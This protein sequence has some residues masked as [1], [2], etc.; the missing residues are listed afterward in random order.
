[1]VRISD[2][3]SVERW[4]VSAHF[5]FHQP[6]GEGWQL[7]YTTGLISEREC[8]RTWH[9]RQ[10]MSR[11]DGSNSCGGGKGS[12]WSKVKSN[13][14]WRNDVASSNW[15][16]RNFSSKPFERMSK[17]IELKL[18]SECR[19]YRVCIAEVSTCHAE[20]VRCGC[21]FRRSSTHKLELSRRVAI[22]EPMKSS[23]RLNTL[24][25]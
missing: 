15:H 20:S 1:M 16:R 4:V 14:P 6:V 25:P 18:L 2:F 19:S 7:G 17:W 12:L 5:H 23:E 11:K 13:L 3:N 24:W 9:Q 8:G 10:H 22:R 21:P